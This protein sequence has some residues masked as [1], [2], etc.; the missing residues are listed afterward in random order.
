LQESPASSFPG[1]GASE[2]SF[3]FFPYAW[4]TLFS[5]PGGE[6]TSWV[7][8][9]S[10]SPPFLF[11]FPASCS[12]RHSP[13]TVSTDWTAEPVFSFLF[14]GSYGVGACAFFRPSSTSAKAEP[15]PPFLPKIPPSEFIDLPGADRRR[16]VGFPPQRIR[17]RR[18]KGRGGFCLLSSDHDYLLLFLRGWVASPFFSFFFLFA[19]F[20]SRHPS[21]SLSSRQIK[22]RR[23]RVKRRYATRPFPPFPLGLRSVGLP[24]S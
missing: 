6:T 1:Q 23:P 13:P 2:K 7:A 19:P 24:C 15:L 4:V 14:P 16:C 12:E 8:H 5:G 9:R 18:K 3:F 17:R 10:P 21:L 22:T 11:F 20:P